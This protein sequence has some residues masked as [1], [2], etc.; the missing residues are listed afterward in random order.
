MLLN[1][2]QENDQDQLRCEEHFDKDT[3]GRRDARSQSGFDVQ[4]RRVET[5]DRGGGN[6]AANNL[7]HNAE[8]GT[9]RRDCA[10]QAKC[11]R[12]LDEFLVSAENTHSK[13]L[14]QWINRRRIH[15]AAQGLGFIDLQQG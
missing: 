6:D 7:A 12:D 13:H 8:P 11:R 1:C 9:Q 2:Q 5:V 10:N 15:V 3:L 14:T 4:E